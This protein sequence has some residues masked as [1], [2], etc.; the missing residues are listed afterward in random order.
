MCPARHCD[1][2]LS[3]LTSFYAVLFPVMLT[4]MLLFMASG[5]AGGAEKSRPLK[6]AVCKLVFLSNICFS[7]IYFLI[8]G[9]CS[10]VQT[11]FKLLFDALKRGWSIMID[12]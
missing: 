4:L 12:D 3:V 2:Q 11:F 6:V 10:S 9:V 8:T 5:A 7:K 1:R